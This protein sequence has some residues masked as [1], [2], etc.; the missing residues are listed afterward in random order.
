MIPFASVP[1]R[2]Q[3]LDAALWILEFERTAHL[4]Y[5]VQPRHR[6]STM[7]TTNEVMRI[8][9]HPHRGLADY[10]HDYRIE[11]RTK[12]DSSI[13]VWTVVDAVFSQVYWPASLAARWLYEG[14][15]L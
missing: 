14:A 6:K 15:S 2:R 11:A 10:V 9:S 3:A 5:G 12:R 7:I 8:Y 13:E 4:V 1:A